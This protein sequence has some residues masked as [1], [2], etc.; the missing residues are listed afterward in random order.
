MVRGQPNL[1]T[2]SRC[3]YPVTKVSLFF[4]VHLHFSFFSSHFDAMCG[5]GAMIGA[6]FTGSGVRAGATFAGATRT[7]TGVMCGTLKCGATV[8]AENINV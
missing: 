5:A 8:M 1:E 4:I 2:V 6:T 7:G 3:V